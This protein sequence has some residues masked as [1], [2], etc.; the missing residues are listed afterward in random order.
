[1]RHAAMFGLTRQNPEH[2]ARPVHDPAFQRRRR[3]DAISSA[4]VNPVRWQW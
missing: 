1:M 3:L 2:P 4:E